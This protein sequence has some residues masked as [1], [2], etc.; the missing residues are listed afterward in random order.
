MEYQFNHYINHSSIGKKLKI[1][2]RVIMPIGIL[3]GII[4]AIVMFSKAGDSK[5]EW[6]VGDTVSGFFT[7][8]G[9]GFLIGLPTL[10]V[11]HG[12]LLY[13]VGEVLERLTEQGKAQEP[14]IEQEKAAVLRNQYGVYCS[15][16][17]NYVKSGDY[18]CSRCESQLIYPDNSEYAS[19]ANRDLENTDQ[20]EGEEWI[21]KDH[22]P[23]SDT[24]AP[25][26]EPEK[27]IRDRN[28]YRSIVDHRYIEESRCPYCDKILKDDSRFCPSCGKK[29]V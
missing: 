2:A 3:L 24:A 7:W 4:L 16:C 12:L 14:K 5:E 21:E 15:K 1:A 20:T 18:S 23:Y 13:G 19:I 17:G 29:I 27:P 28:V 11:V 22:A 9:F 6:L 10:S 25:Q 26:I 8:I